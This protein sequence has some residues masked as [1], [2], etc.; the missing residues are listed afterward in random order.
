MASANIIEN[1]AKWRQPG[2][3]MAGKII[4]HRDSRRRRR[5]RLVA[6]YRRN[7]WRHESISETD[8]SKKIMAA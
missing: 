1:Q 8:I 3:L 5:K 4:R 2:N 7:G 6:A